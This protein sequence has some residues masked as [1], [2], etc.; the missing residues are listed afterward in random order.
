GF[1][2]Q[3]QNNY[4]SIL[5]TQGKFAEAEPI[6]RGCVETHRRTHGKELIT[7]GNWADALRALGQTERAE[8]LLRET[9]AACRQIRPPDDPQV[10][11]IVTALAR[12][13]EARGKTAEALELYH[14]NLRDEDRVLGPDHSGTLWTLNSYLN[15]LGARKASEDEPLLREMV[16]L[17][18]QSPA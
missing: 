5:C 1:T 11:P 2:L 3:L 17:R 12:T 14:I 6:L 9:L 13:L 16:A 15:L 4:A 7:E 18:E 8:A 10:L